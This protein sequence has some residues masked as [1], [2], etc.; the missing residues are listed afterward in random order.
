[1]EEIKDKKQEEVL[2]KFSD[3]VARRRSLKGGFNMYTATIG[4]DP[5]QEFDLMEDE[6]LRHWGPT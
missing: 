3:P 4:I 5:P 1:M 6:I 2:E